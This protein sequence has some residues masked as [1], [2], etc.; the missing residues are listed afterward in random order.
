M[1]YLVFERELH[2]NLSRGWVVILVGLHILFR[3]EAPIPCSFQCKEYDKGF[4][5]VGLRVYL[6][7]YIAGKKH[8]CCS[9][10]AD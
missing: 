1:R 3:F 10:L 6:A 4:A 2:E 8:F 5:Y 9:N 7:E